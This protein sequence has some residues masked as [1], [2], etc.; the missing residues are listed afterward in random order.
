MNTNPYERISKNICQFENEIKSDPDV[1]F[2]TRRFHAELV[3]FNQNLYLK[4]MPEEKSL[5]G[6]KYFI[7]RDHELEGLDFQCFKSSHL[8]DLV[9]RYNRDNRW[10][11]YELEIYVPTL[12]IYDVS[13]ISNGSAAPT[14]S[15]IDPLKRIKIVVPNTVLKTWTSSEF[16]ESESIGKR[17]RR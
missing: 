8:N 17:F 5:F 1:I 4:Y 13:F 2:L 11:T 14:F 7:V 12:S 6:M 15:D 16:P 3:H 10:Q 9:E